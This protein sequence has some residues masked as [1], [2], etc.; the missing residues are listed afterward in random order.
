MQPKVYSQ[1]FQTDKLI[2][3]FSKMTNRQIFAIRQMLFLYSRINKNAMSFIIQLY[4]IST[5]FL[6][7]YLV[8]RICLKKQQHSLS[9][10][11]GKCYSVPAGQIS[12][13]EAV[14]SKSRLQRKIAVFCDRGRKKMH[15][16]L[17]PAE[18]DIMGGGQFM[19]FEVQ[20]KLF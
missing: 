18:G 4:M 1:T 13:F 16:N 2:S 9:N 8:A 12:T 15:V 6:A 19:Y 3:T 20:R 11:K 5:I 14:R 17:T 10:S 7:A